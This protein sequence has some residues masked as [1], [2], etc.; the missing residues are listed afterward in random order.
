MKDKK[1]AVR[2]VLGDGDYNR[3][4]KCNACGGIMIFKGVGEYEC[5]DCRDI[6]FDDYGKARSYIERNPGSTQAQITEGTGVSAKSI[7][8]MLKESRLEIASDSRTF[9]KCDICGINIRHGSLCDKCEVAYHR[10]KE[11]Q[12]RAA[13]AISGYGM[14]TKPRDDGEM[15]YINR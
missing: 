12:E 1:I 6:D 14:D 13:R 4:Y 2:G 9:L 7:R 15:R 5:E 11:E 10:N 8:Q 3:P